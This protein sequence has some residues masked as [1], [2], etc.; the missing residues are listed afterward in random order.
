MQ[1][2]FSVGKRSFPRCQ[3]FWRP[4][5]RCPVG[6]LHMYRFFL[7]SSSEAIEQNQEVCGGQ[8]P[9]TVDLHKKKQEASAE[10]I[11]FKLYDVFFGVIHLFP[12]SQ[13]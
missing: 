3:D 4:P 11:K 2:N 6:T 9:R 1:L 8:L 13:R 7:S 5:Y 10:R 12:K